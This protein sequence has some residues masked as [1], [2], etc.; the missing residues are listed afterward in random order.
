MQKLRNDEL[1]R[2]SLNA[3]LQQEKMP[4]IL[5][6]DNIRSAQNIGSVFR[7]A[8][9]F[10]VKAIYLCGISATPP[11]KDI[12]KTALGATESVS[13]SYYKNTK[14]A[15]DI[16]RNESYQIVAIEQ[17]KESISLENF[18][19]DNRA[20]ALIL[21]HEMDGVSQ[22]IIN[23]CDSCI[24]IPQA[25]IKHSINVAVCAGIVCWEFFR[26]YAHKLKGE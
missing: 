26:N 24:E 20:V 15:I 6:L 14:D 2:P 10:G 19:T 7:T 3:Y 12:L 5:V 13:W 23:E 11:H 1:K 21:G 16:L 22:D 8:D 18:R 9:A 17:V 25:G 4:L